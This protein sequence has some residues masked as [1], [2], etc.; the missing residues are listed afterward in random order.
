MTPLQVAEVQR[1]FSLV[2]PIKDKAA[3][4]FYGRLFDLDPSL[5]KL[6]KGDMKEQGKKLM[7]TLA[8]VVA[9]LSSPKSILPAVEALGRKHVGYGV[10]DRHYDT[11]GAA[12][13]WTLGQGLGKAF[14]A[15]V[16]EAWTAAY[17]LLA[18]V[19]KEGAKKAR[20]A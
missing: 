5:A 7:S 1:T 6:F 17:T 12:L 16:K 2:V 14:T 20:A 13:L 19:M 10:E 4:I 15:E 3:E 11:V 9:G 18:G 8:T